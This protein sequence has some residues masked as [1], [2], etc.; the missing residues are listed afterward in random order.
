MKT[1]IGEKKKKL[2]LA[3]EMYNANE[4]SITGNEE[5]FFCWGREAT[6]RGHVGCGDILQLLQTSYGKFPSTMKT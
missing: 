1:G 4:K 5:F 2:G 3:M 6:N